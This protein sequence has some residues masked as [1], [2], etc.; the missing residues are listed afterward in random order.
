ML[1]HAFKLSIQDTAKIKSYDDISMFLN[2]K[3]AFFLPAMMTVLLHLAP[4]SNDLVVYSGIKWS[5]T[6]TEA[7]SGIS[8]SV[9][10]YE[11]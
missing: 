1:K 8:W 5:V 7:C 11:A 6:G 4:M 10:G 2:C 9:T 3:Y